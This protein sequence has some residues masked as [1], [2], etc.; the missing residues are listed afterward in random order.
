MP[1]GVAIMPSAVAHR[2]GR[3]D[4]EARIDPVHDRGI[5]GLADA[6]DPAILD[7]DDR[8]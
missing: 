5:A 6:D 3:A 2:G 1:P 4:D 8:P 7:A